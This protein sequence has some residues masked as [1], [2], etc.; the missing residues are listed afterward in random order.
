MVVWNKIIESHVIRMFRKVSYRWWGIDIQF[1][2]EYGDREGKNISLQ[3]SFCRLI[4]TK[5]TRSCLQN[6][7][8]YLRK[9][10]KSQRNFSFECYAGI[11]VLVVPLFSKEKY[12]GSMICSGMRLSKNDALHNI[13]MKKLKMLGIKKSILEHTYNELNNLNDISD[14]SKEY[15]LDFM[16]LVAKDVMELYE[17]LLEKEEAIRRHEMLQEKIY[18]EK[19]KAIIGNSPIIKEV[20]DTL[21]LIENYESPVLVEGASGTGKE[22]LSVA[23]H[24][25]S[26]RKDGMFVMQNCSAFSDTLLSSEL[27]GHEKGSFTDATSFKKGIF[28]TANG[29]TLFLDEIGEMDIKAQS[30]LLRVL[31][32]GTFYR[33]GG[34][35]LKRVDVRVI[36]ATNR[37]LKK[38]VEQ[39]LF[40]EDL[41]YRINTIHIVLPPLRE[42]KEDIKLLVEHF[43]K[44]HT[45]IYNTEKKDISPDA[46]KKMEAYNWPGNIRELRNLVERLI[47]L[48]GKNKTIESKHLP[49]EITTSSCKKPHVGNYR[50]DLILRDALKFF[51]RDIIEGKLRNFNWNKTT[52][53]MELGISRASLNKKIEEYNI[54]SN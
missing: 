33:V 40:R 4:H 31:E 18:K 15:L 48:S 49:A 34:S 45:E 6:C 7:K 17:M 12:V 1:F 21:E 20:F 50:K 37:D 13:K 35:E 9:L 51:E 36:V 25:N 38:L 22:L 41:Y 5:R 8:R 3:N 54:Y 47:I 10:N 27:F 24:Y 16:K 39:G 23:I 29:G 19:Y 46:I 2:D 42:R 30:K 52:V 32:D 11:Q 26:P 28:E 44:T 53:S 14:I 43:L